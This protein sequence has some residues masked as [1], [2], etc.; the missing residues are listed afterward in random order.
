MLSRSQV[1]MVEEISC[2]GA[3]LKGLPPLAVGEEFLLRF[4]ALEAFA[5]VKWANGDTCGIEFDL[6]LGEAD[7]AELRCSGP[8]AS[9]TIRLLQHKQAHEDW[10]SGLAR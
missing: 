2:T 5:T 8:A 3:K 4:R 9:T 7:V 6:P 1:A 10:R